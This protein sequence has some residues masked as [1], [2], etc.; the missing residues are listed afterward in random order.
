MEQGS[1]ILRGIRQDAFSFSQEMKQSNFGDQRLTDRLVSVLDQLYKHPS[2]PIN[3]ACESGAEI[4][5]AYRLMGNRSVDEEKI[6]KPHQEQT[7]ARMRM[8]KLVFVAQ[9][10]TTLSYSSHLALEGA[11]QIGR[12]TGASGR[13]LFVHTAEAFDDSGLPLGILGQLQWSREELGFDKERVDHPLSG[14]EIERWLI[15]LDALAATQKQLPGTKVIV[16]SDRESDF[17]EYLL[18]AKGHGLAVVVRGKSNIRTDS[19]KKPVVE[20]LREETPLGEMML[21]ITQVAGPKKRR[22]K[23]EGDAPE[24]KRKERKSRTAR[25]RVHAKRIILRKANY[26]VGASASDEERSFWAILVEELSAPEGFECLQWL[27]F[28][29]EDLSLDPKAKAFEVIDWYKRRWGIETFHK[30]LKSGC[31]V[32]SARFEAIDRTKN[33]V[34]MM[35]LI[36]W[37]LHALVYAQREMPEESCVRQLSAAEWKVLYLKIKKTRAFPAEPPSM[38]QATHWIARLGGFMG[39]KGDGEPGPLTLWRGWQRLMDLTE[40][41]TL[42]ESNHAPQRYG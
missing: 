22:K 1:S 34:T 36:A 11:G 42:L 13:G 33:F 41:Y 21:E 29:T 15:S 2:L 3:G 28:T 10:T 9:D 20:A 16:L 4:K 40:G 30:I 6:L 32:E 35:S 23:K 12:G 31:R 19:T 38:R 18:K 26:G 27:L 7:V 37:R 39:R 25:L 17:N 5:A 8:R 24:R 14:R